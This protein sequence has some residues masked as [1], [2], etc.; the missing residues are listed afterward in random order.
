[1]HMH[2]RC[3]AAALGEREGHGHA[4]PVVPLEAEERVPLQLGLCELGEEPVRLAGVDA[5]GPRLR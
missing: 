4:T 2:V 5:V 3:L 1:M